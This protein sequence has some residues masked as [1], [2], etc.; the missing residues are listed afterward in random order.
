MSQVGGGPAIMTT[1][2]LI[3]KNYIR[4]NIV[5]ELN[6]FRYALHTHDERI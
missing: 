3:K 2:A 4:I 6:I 1:D 5:C